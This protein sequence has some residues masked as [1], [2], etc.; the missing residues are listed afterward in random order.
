MK[1]MIVYCAL[2]FKRKS[3]YLHKKLAFFADPVN[4]RIPTVHYFI[5]ITLEG[6]EIKINGCVSISMEHWVSNLY[7]GN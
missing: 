4:A 3:I 5:E 6:V 2:Y 7:F 1:L